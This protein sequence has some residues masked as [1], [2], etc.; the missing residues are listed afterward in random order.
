MVA[1]TIPIIFP[2]QNERKPSKQILTGLDKTLILLLVLW[3]EQ[4]MAGQ[5]SKRD[6]DFFNPLSVKARVSFMLPV[7]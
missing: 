6:Q 1:S 7:R 5:L 2:T 4:Q 3:E